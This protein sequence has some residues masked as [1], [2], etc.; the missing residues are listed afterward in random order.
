MCVD[1]HRQ[2][3]YDKYSKIYVKTLCK[4]SMLVWGKLFV[5]LT[6]FQEKIKYFKGW[7][8]SITALK[9]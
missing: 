5:L 1:I 7:E 9:T 4:L 8:M 2:R 3:D 6:L